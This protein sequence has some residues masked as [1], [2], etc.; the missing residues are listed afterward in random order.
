ML[1][2]PTNRD[3]G[4]EGLFH[5]CESKTGLIVIDD[6]ARETG[7]H[8]L[9]GADTWA[10]EWILAGVGKSLVNPDFDKQH[11]NIDA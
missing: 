5:I 1:A 7:L 3:H 10:D 9:Q 4:Y 8:A 11:N 6:G 2:S